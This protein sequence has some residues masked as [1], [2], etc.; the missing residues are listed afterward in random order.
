M[1]SERL[2]TGRG[3]QPGG[4]PGVP[5]IA[6]LG[7]GSLCYQWQ[8]L[9]LVQPV[10]WRLAGPTLP[11]EFSRK[12]KEGE[13]KDILTAVIDET[14]G[15]DV[16]T[17][18]SVSSLS[19]LNDVKDELRIREGR[20]RASWISSFD[21]DGNQLGETSHEIAQRIRDWLMTTDSDAVVWTAIPPDFG[22]RQFTIAAAIRHFCDLDQAKKQDAR[23]YIARAPDEV[24]T[25]LRRALRDAGLL[26]GAD[27]RPIDV[28]TVWQD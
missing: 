13:R 23:N 11:I 17:R 24:D 5:T 12:S 7:W 20:T 1:G 22:G 8:G 6:I 9:S 28:A 25:P 3:W 16:P 15:E 26:D 18:I 21:R 27:P 2:P 4:A 14:N 10:R 19:T